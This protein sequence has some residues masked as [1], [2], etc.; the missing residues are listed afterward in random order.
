MRENSRH[1]KPACAVK[2]APVPI[3]I[4]C[5]QCKVEIELWSDDTEIKCGMCGVLVRNQDGASH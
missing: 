3:E 5:P 4:Q 2:S 1:E